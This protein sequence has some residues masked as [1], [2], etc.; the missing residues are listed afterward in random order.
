MTLTTLLWFLP[1]GLEPLF[2]MGTGLALM[3]G[4][5][6]R[7]EAFSLIARLLLMITLGPILVGVVI[8]AVFEA[9]GLVPTGWIVLALLLGVPLLIWAG[10]RWLLGGLLGRE[11]AGHVIGELALAPFRRRRHRRPE[12]IVVQVPAPVQPAPANRRR[13][14]ARRPPTSPRRSP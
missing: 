5:I 6:S 12:V 7:G 2:L 13:R 8:N 1:E 9:L 14:A 10:F 11:G 3:L 4:L